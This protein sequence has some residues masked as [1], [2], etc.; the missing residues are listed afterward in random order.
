MYFFALLLTLIVFI[1]VYNNY[2]SL[3]PAANFTDHEYV[4]QGEFIHYLKSLYASLTP[5][6]TSDDQWP[7]SATHKVFNLAMIKT[8]EVRRGQ[9]QD[10]YVRQTI[11]GK[12]DD[13]LR[14]K[15]PIE[16]KHILQKAEGKRKVV[17][18]E[19]APGCGKS[20]LSVFISQ[21]WGEGKL[22]TEYQLIILIRLRDPA[23]QRATCIAELLPS[24]DPATARHVEAKMLANNCR[25]VLFI[26]DGWDELPPN[27]RQKSLFHEL[28]KP[29][30]LQ[31][32][33][34]HESA[35]IVTSRPIASADLHPVVSSRV[36]I[37]GFTPKELDEYFTECLKG[38]VNALQTLKE[39]IDQNPAVASTCYLP[40]N[41]SI[42]VHLF[43]S[44]SKTLPTTQFEIFSQFIL[45]CIYRHKKKSTE[46]Q[47]IPALESLDKLPESIEEPFQFL[48]ELAYKGI[49]EDRVVFE[50]PHEFNLLGL[51][52]GVE[53]FAIGKV[54]SY[55]FIHLSVQEL[56]AAI[57]I[58][59]RKP[60]N[61]QASVFNQHYNYRLDAVF[62]FYA[63]ITK[64]KVFGINIVDQQSIFR[65]PY[66]IRYSRYQLFILHC[67]HEA[68][69]PTLCVSVAQQFGHKLN[70]NSITLT[71]S[72][73][74]SLGFFLSCVCKMAAGAAV[75]TVHLSRCSI[76]DQGCKYLVSGLQKGLD[77]DNAVSTLLIMEMRNNNIGH[78]GVCHLSSFLKIGCVKYL[79]LSNDNI[80]FR[81]GKGDN[82]IILQGSFAEQLKQNTT[83]KRLLL[84]NCDIATLSAESLA[85]GLVANQHMVELDISSNE[86]C[87][88][89]IQHLTH[90]LKVNQGL[91]KVC[92][93]ST[94]FTS[95]SAESLAVALATNIYLEELDIGHNAL[96]ND[97]IQ[98]LEHALKVNKGLKKLDLNH[99]H[100]TSQGA[101]SLANAI[102][103]NEHL[104]ELNISKNALCDDGIQHLAQALQVNQ[105]LKVLYICNSSMTDMG[106]EHLATSLIHNT[107]LTTL[108][109]NNT[110]TDC[111]SNMFT[112]EIAPFLTDCLKRNL[113]LIKLKL[114]WNFWS[115]TTS[116]EKAV[117]DIRKKRGLP[118][119]QVSGSLTF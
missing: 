13:I 69:N 98:H 82:V 32:I 74:F 3:S 72:D 47:I 94:G 118:F 108:V 64:L 9:I 62:Q 34:L 41:A 105:C 53:S 96:C 18:L 5:T 19:G 99:C 102:S 49:I 51:L 10:E 2:C 114:Q 71:P 27:L 39:R 38:D 116:I 119:I 80:H 1:L 31:N 100:L 20:T 115:P 7:P 84:H 93:N 35:V 68:Q 75:F 78:H 70:L 67:L 109:L 89:G 60:E 97:G 65:Y 79:D 23:V 22:F 59:R 63:A 16:L 73:C 83:L 17:L 44:L 76:G 40:L 61:D 15:E 25:D 52:Q 111:W 46:L 107:S 104:E 85:K 30:L 106:L 54:V 58:A 21:Q 48:C 42:L 117:N 8:T 57:H 26:L 113:T 110:D 29:G 28:I 37:L 86:V 12:V 95:H 24:P 14:E 4:L 81:V 11:T 66:F 55:H 56:L 45:N 50:I 112:D 77:T 101:V 33:P 103:A 6:H 88:D 92:L 36:E 87:D 91:K 43:M 90:A